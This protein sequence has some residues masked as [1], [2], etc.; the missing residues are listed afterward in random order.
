ME[1][2]KKEIEVK[3]EI[4]LCDAIIAKNCQELTQELKANY[5]LYHK[6][7]RALDVITVFE[8]EKADLLEKGGVSNG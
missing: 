8:A 4:D 1:K 7:F 5:K 2:K 6:V 3:K